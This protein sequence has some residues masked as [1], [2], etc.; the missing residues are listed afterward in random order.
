[1]IET[2]WLPAD[3]VLVAERAIA[4]RV[5]LLLGEQDARWDCTVTDLG[6][7]GTVRLVT[8]F[9]GEPGLSCPLTQK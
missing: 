9:D 3:D 1:M 8:V 4:A 2:G 7:S 6:S 5:A